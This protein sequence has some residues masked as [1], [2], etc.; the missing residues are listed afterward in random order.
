[1]TRIAGLKLIKTPSGK[2]THVTLSMKYHAKLIEDMLDHTLIAGAAKD[3]CI[4]W[5]KAKKDLLA[6]AEKKSKKK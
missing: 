3:E 6:T 2:V 5:E 1:M 4:P